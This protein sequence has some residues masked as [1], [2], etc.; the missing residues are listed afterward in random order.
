MKVAPRNLPRLVYC[1]KARLAK[2]STE[3]ALH[4][5]LKVSQVRNSAVDVTGALLMC[6][7]WFVQ[8]LEGPMQAVLHTYGRITRDPRHGEVKIIEAIPTRD[9]H[10][11]SWSMCGRQVSPVDREIVHVLSSG[12]AFDPTKL[13]AERALN[14]LLIVGKMQLKADTLVV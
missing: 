12:G 5:I 8:T 11:A 4:E 6:N 14:L 7:G 2:A 3:D 13:N 1:S 10:F 9:R